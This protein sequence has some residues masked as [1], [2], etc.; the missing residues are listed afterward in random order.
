MYAAIYPAKLKQLSVDEKKQILEINSKLIGDAGIRRY[1]K[2]NYQSGNFWFNDIKTDAD[3]ESM[4]K[5]SDAFIKDSEAQWF[6]DSWVGLCALELYKETQD[7]KYLN[8]TFKHFNRSLGQ[9]TYDGDN[10]LLGA[11]GLP[12]V[13]KSFPESYNT[14]ISDS[15]NKFF[16]PSPI[17]PLNWAKASFN[18]L[19]IQLSKIR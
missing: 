12:I 16:V 1:F 8:L 15:G 3:P 5:R 13:K 14:V 10:K 11:N 18:L 17:T 9:I 7:L 19:L 6:F 2:D 4:K